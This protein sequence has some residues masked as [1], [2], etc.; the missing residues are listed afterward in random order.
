VD[1]EL[2]AGVGRLSRNFRIRALGASKIP[3]NEID[4]ARRRL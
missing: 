3:S 1:K 4:E 2:L